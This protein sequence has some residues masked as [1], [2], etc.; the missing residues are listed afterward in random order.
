[1][2]DARTIC[3]PAAAGMDQAIAVLRAGGDRDLANALASV[4]KRWTTVIDRH[5][6]SVAAAELATR[7]EAA[8]RSARTVF[9]LE[10]PIRTFSEANAR[11]HW[12]A[13]FAKSGDQRPVTQMAMRSNT[14]ARGLHLALPATIQLTRIAPD[15]LDVDDNLDCSCKH[16]RDGVADFFGVNDRDPRIRFTPVRQQ[17]RATYGV[18]IEVIAP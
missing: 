10:L 11:G 7:T 12:G 18:L 13:K 3:A 9:V 4:R 2:V 8:E 1:M 16:I 15:A 5:T 6:A 14:N 17:K